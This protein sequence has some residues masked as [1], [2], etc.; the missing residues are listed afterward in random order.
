MKAPYQEDWNDVRPVHDFWRH[1]VTYHFKVVEADSMAVLQ[2]LL[3][4][5]PRLQ[6]CNACIAASVM[7]ERPVC[8]PPRVL[9]L[10]ACYP[11][12]HWLSD[13]S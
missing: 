12:L 8:M 1:S 7:T 2:D 10:L 4:G 6:P 5:C 9:L 11:D 13:G 3:K